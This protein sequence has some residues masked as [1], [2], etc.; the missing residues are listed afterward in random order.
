MI[1]K[2]ETLNQM[3]D[4]F[5]SQPLVTSRELE[6]F[7]LN[8]AVARTGD[9]FS[10]FVENFA[11]QMEDCQEVYLHK[12]FIGHPGCGK[13][14]ELYQLLQRVKRADFFACIGRCDLE[15]DL[16]DIAYTDVLFFLLDLLIGTAS[17]LGMKL[18]DDLVESIYAYWEEE[19]EVTEVV[20]S[21]A[22]LEAQS[23]VKA[24]AGLPGLLELMAQIKG[25]IKNSSDSRTQIRRKIIPKS[26][27]LIR[28]IEDV[29]E[30][31]SAQCQQKNMR[32]IP[33][34]ILDGLDRVPLGQAKKIFRDNGSAFRALPIH[35]V[36]T[37][38]IALTYTQEY[39][40][41]LNYFPN[42]SKLPMIK[43]RNWEM[44]HY[45]EGYEEG[46]NTMRQ[47]VGKRAE[48]SLFDEDALEELIDKT[49]GYIRDLFRCISNAAI[50]AQRRGAASISKGDVT[51]VLNE[52]ESDINSRYSD[53][54]IPELKKIYGGEKFVSSSESI[55]RLLQACAVLEYN[56]KRWCDLHP[57][58]EKWL[59]ECNKL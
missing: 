37:F 53:E 40:D 44:G 39:S 36:T 12:L 45:A 24:K 54:D 4:A 31:I 30:N 9:Q 14:T 33:L 41:I 15:L 59:K 1:G 49:G 8:T 32:K 55:T 2:A 11:L 16:V 38:P 18:D 43:L 56:G 46:K 57:L 22:Q 13:T 47:I 7:Y 27:E 3:Q 26:S 28:K 52:L 19:I 42:P 34:V 23:S 58:V 5:N 20:S 48:L 25:V 17:E 51:V 10:D 21:Q 50:R 6:E 29:I 35:L